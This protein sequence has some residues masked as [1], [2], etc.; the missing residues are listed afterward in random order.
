[1]TASRIRSVDLVLS[2]KFDLPTEQHRDTLVCYTD[3]DELPISNTSCSDAWPYSRKR[4]TAMLV[5]C[6]YGN[7]IRACECHELCRPAA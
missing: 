6:R 1:M 5:G 4:D 2:I 3:G 7:L